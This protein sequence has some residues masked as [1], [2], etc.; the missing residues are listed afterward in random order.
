MSPVKITSSE[1][2]GTEWRIYRHLSISTQ[3]KAYIVFKIDKIMH[4][5]SCV[6]ITIYSDDSHKYFYEMARLSQ[7]IILQ[8]KW[9]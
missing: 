8:S 9:Y 6:I 2:V 5:D 7:M 4:L 1:D 3:S